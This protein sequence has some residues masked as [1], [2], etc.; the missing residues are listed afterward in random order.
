MNA[1]IVAYFL[2]TLGWFIIIRSAA[3]YVRV[4]QMEKIIATE[5]S[6]ENIV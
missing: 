3:D 4:K 6:V 1:D 2:M 5:P